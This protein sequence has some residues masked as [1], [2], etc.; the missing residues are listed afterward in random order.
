M[1][2]ERLGGIGAS[3][4]QLLAVLLLQR[5][6]FHCNMARALRLLLLL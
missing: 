6:P 4:G 1:G 5:A 2:C 3:A